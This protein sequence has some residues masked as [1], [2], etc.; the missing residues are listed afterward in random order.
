MPTDKRARQR[1]AREIKQ[2]EIQKQRQRARTVRR[3]L[4]VAVVVLVVVGVIYLV[5][6]GGSAKPNAGHT[7]TTRTVPAST[8]PTTTAAPTACPPATA[9]GAPKQVR[10]FPGGIASGCVNPAATYDWNLQTTAGDLSVLLDKSNQ[11]A[12]NIF[13]ALTRY[14]FFD[15]IIFHRVIPG[16]MDQG[17]DP[18]GTG[19]GGP[20]FSWTGTLPA[21][22]C[23]AK[24]QCYPIGTV[25]MANSSNGSANSTNN[26]CTVAPT[27]NGSQF[28][29]VTGSAGVSLPPCYTIIGTVVKGLAVADKI[30]SEGSASGTPKTTYRIIKATITQVAA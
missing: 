24:Q 7:T 28:F 9:A 20:G 14:H 5:T 19:T 29:I 23:Y 1:A 16:F 4:T 17:G 30:N 6:S 13:V 22:S 8:A 26:G 21:G 27:T 18:T 10:A 11:Q 12:E 3:G 2:A 25:A 15:G